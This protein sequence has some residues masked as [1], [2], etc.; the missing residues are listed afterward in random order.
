MDLVLPLLELHLA[1]R[2]EATQPDELPL[3]ERDIGDLQVSHVAGLL[4]VAEVELLDEFLEGLL[5]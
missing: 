4:Q 2:V 5:R 3:G 1:L